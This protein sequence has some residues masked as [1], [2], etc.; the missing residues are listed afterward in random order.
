M[1]GVGV[2]LLVPLAR[3][4]SLLGATLPFWLVVAPLVDLGWIERRRIALRF[5]QGLRSV[6]SK[7][8]AIRNVRAQRAPRATACSA[9]R[10]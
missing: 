3:G 8:R 6:A 2:L 5:T 1:I 10:S 9:A 7:R 4:D